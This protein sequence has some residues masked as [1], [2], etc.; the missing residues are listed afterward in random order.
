[1]HTH[2]KHRA[3]VEICLF[4]PAKQD[5]CLP[6]VF[7]KAKAGLAHVTRSKQAGAI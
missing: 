5:E 2:T 4:P 1:M 3:L 7:S 6:G